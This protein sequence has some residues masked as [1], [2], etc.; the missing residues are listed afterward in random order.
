MNTTKPVKQ[1]EVVRKWYQLD[2]AGRVLGRLAVEVS[3]LLMG[4]NE[5]RYVT[6]LDLGHHVVV[7][8]VGKIK[9]TGGKEKD[10]T[11][12]RYSGYPGGLKKE[13]YGK[14]FSRRPTEVLRKAVD[15]MLPDNKLKDKRLSRLHLYVDDK[16]SQKVKFTEIR[17]NE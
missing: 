6:Y 15:G 1:K 10:K 4:K 8:N 3:T 12:Y 14:L 13:T 7:T 2:A 5:V 17:K 9:V 11:Y 16:I